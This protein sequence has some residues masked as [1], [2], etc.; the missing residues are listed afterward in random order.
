MEAIELEQQAAAPGVKQRRPGGG[1]KRALQAEHLK[2]LMEKV[3]ANPGLSSRE[4]AAE[5][6]KSSEVKV[7]PSTIISALKGLGLS[8]V[9]P[10]KA[11][12]PQEPVV[13][14]PGHYTKAHRRIAPAGKYPSS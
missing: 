3:T 8:R 1:R 6:F 12:Q 11:T 9:K 13:Q 14:T 2:L 10:V 4:L 5:L 7:G